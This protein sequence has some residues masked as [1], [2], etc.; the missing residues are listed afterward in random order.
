MSEEEREGGA[1]RIRRAAIEVLLDVGLN[2]AT[3]RQVTDRA[4]VG[5]GLL[6]HYFRW[7]ELRAAA[8]EVIFDA[9]GDDQF[10]AHAAPDRA[11]EHYLATAFSDDAKVYWMLWLEATELAATDSTMA[12]ALQRASQRML[13][14]LTACLAAGNAQALWHLPDADGAALR[15]TAL[16]D[17]LAGMLLS[18]ASALTPK[19][20]ERHL[21]QLFLLETRAGRP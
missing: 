21:R 2:A 9:V 11:L 14:Q 10:A 5:R 8:W 6:N 18:G 1:D 20:A 7:P 4:G 19:E 3:T 13:A 15:L 12:V 17:G 16:Y